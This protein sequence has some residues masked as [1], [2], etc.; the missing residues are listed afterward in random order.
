[1][2]KLTSGGVDKIKTHARSLSIE[3]S[4]QSICEKI[5]S[6]AYKWKQDEIPEI[7]FIDEVN[8]L[9]EQILRHGK[10]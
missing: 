8:A 1:M 4:T 10:K 5:K 3:T 9:L 2:P 7:E 6:L